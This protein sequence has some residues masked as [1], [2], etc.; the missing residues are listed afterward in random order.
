VR[1]DNLPARTKTQSLVESGLVGVRLIPFL[2]H[3][4]GFLAGQNGVE[5]TRPR[6]DQPQPHPA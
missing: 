3:S 4:F 2:A 6:Q 5:T 1:S